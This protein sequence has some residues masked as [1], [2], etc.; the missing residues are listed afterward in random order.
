MQFGT[1]LTKLTNCSTYCKCVAIFC[2]VWKPL[3]CH[4]MI[5]QQLWSVLLKFLGA[6]EHKGKFSHLSNYIYH[7]KSGLYGIH[8]THD[9]FCGIYTNMIFSPHSQWPMRILTCVMVQ[10][11][12]QPFWQNLFRELS[13]DKNCCCWEKDRITPLQEKQ[14]NSQ[15][16]EFVQNASQAAMNFSDPL[17]DHYSCWW[18]IRQMKALS[19]QK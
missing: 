12:M 8:S 18:P 15:C 14:I 7:E 16:I 2:R 17:C 19:D 10:W 9:S 6:I 5:P 3:E 11:Y 4:S 1:S 13:Q